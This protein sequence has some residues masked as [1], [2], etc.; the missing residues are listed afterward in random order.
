MSL[1]DNDGL[2]VTST[3][4]VIVL[5]ASVASRAVCAPSIPPCTFIARKAVHMLVYLFVTRPRHDNR[6]TQ[7]RSPVKKDVVWPSGNV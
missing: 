2:I 1:N 7:D 3:F 4:V 5:R 6:S